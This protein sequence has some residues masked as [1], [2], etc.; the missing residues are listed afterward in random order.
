MVPCV[1]E[2]VH[3]LRCQVEIT[4][5]G[6]LELLEVPVRSRVKRVCCSVRGSKSINVQV[7]TEAATAM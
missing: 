3:L 4:H 7:N 5:D 1:I 2:Q 6:H